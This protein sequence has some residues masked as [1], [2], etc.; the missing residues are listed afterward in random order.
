MVG[1]LKVGGTEACPATVG[2]VEGKTF[3]AA[4]QTSEFFK[5]SEVWLMVTDMP[6]G[7]V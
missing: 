4:S 3:M 6:H 7:D 2:S 5:T 1:Q